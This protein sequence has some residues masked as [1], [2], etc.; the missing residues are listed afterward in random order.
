MCGKRARRVAF[1]ADDTRASC[2]SAHFV[3]KFAH[4]TADRGVSEHRSQ[5]VTGSAPPCGLDG[6]SKSDAATFNLR[7]V[8]QLADRGGIKGNISRNGGERIYHMRGSSSYAETV[9]DESNGERW[10]CTEED[11]RRAGWRPR[12]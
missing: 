11:A 4:G 9:I 12:R 8:H 7:R 5:T 2:D 3:Q 10:F 1:R 6:G